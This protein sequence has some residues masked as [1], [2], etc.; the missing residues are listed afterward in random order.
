MRPLVAVAKADSTPA[1]A[2][3]SLSEIV[4]TQIRLASSKVETVSAFEM[5]E[6]AT[7]MKRQMQHRWRQRRRQE[8]AEQRSS[9]AFVRTERWGID[10]VD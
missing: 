9:D 4:Y 1:S 3:Q 2:V 7:R 10:V 8:Q 5:L 6:Q